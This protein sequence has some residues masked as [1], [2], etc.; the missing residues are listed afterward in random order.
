MDCNEWRAK[1][2]QAMLEALEADVDGSPRLD[3]DARYYVDA[4]TNTS[5]VPGFLSDD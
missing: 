1:E 5:L 4:Y 2:V 3:A